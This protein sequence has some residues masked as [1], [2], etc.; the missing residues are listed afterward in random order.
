MRASVYAYNFK[1]SHPMTRAPRDTL[2]RML[3][4]ERDTAVL[5]TSIL[6]LLWWLYVGLG[7]VMCRV[8][9]CTLFNANCERNK[10]PK[11]PS[12][13]RKH[14]ETCGNTNTQS[15]PPPSTTNTS[16][17]QQPA[18]RSDGG[19]DASNP[20]NISSA[21][22]RTLKSNSVVLLVYL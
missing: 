5:L 9:V 1:P 12:L 8:C 15:K 20:L 10:E 19:G 4:K 18:Q 17:S 3:T 22:T 2:I 14:Q 16:A 21:H 6:L 11:I 7:V 13:K